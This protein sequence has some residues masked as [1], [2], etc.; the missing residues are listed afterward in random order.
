MAE[1]VKDQDKDIQKYADIKDNVISCITSGEDY[2]DRFKQ[3]W[4]AIEK[5][6]RMVQPVE[7]SN[8]EDWQSKVFVGLQAKTSESA[9]SNMSAMI[10][11]SESFFSISATKQRNREDESA[12]EDLY[13]I[14]F[15]RGGF[16]QVKDFFLQEAIDQ[17][18]S[19]LKML[20]RADKTG[21]DFVWRSCFQCLVDPQAG[22]DWSKAKFWVDQYTKDASFIVDEIRKGKQSLYEQDQLKEALQSMEDQGA[23]MRVDELET[24]KNIDGTGYISIPKAYKQIMLNEFW[25]LLPNESGK[26]VPKVVTMINKDFIIRCDDNEYGFIPVVPGRIKPRKYDHY[27]KGFLLNGMGTQDLMNSMINLGFDSAKICSMDISVLD[28]ERIADPA[29]IQYKPL[30]VWLVKGNPNDAV[31]MTRSS[32]MS[33]MNDILNGIGILDTIH[34]DVTGVTRQAEG[35]SAVNASGEDQTLGEYKLK[36]QA[37][38]KRFLSVAKQF[39]ED[40][41]KTL[42]QNVYKIVVNRKLFSQEACD[43]MIGFKPIMIQDPAS[44][45]SVKVGEMPRLKLEDLGKKDVMQWNF[46]ASGVMQFSQRQE[47]MQKLQMALTA[48]LQ[49]PTLTA[50]TNIDT[51]WR[52]IFQVS[53]IPD[54]EE[55]VKSKEDVQKL[56]EFLSGMQGGVPQ[57]GVMPSKVGPPAGMPTRPAGPMP[58]MPPPMQ[59]QMNGVM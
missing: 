43:E 49:N 57:G 16:Y 59:P 15:S 23:A 39:E 6:V 42:L 20:V 8:K 29:S 58:M 32:A 36:L 1:E 50:L 18:T 27:G 34:Q 56:K 5:Q 19:Y 25:G 13:R 10:F 3:D 37:V 28:A 38:D 33:A 54:W 47:I 31:R 2:R 44:G 45:V 40:A 14:I 53:E 7:W 26:L 41:I 24:I 4:D 35:S 22:N 48:A 30:A 52:R 9:Y 51:L 21:I 11:P 46:S 55:I 17:G 12:L